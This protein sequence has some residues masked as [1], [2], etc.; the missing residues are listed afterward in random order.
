ME[1]VKDPRQP[2]PKGGFKTNEEDAR[3]LE[4]TIMFRMAQTL[5]NVGV[6]LRTPES[7]ALYELLLIALGDAARRGAAKSKAA[8]E[9]ARTMIA[10]RRA[11]D[12]ACYTV[13]GD[14][15]T[16]ETEEAVLIA[17]QD[18]VLAQIDSALA[19]LKTEGADG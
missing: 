6:N 5:K 9:A 10:G 18:S 7:P 19:G 16:M 4:Q 15:A 12:F 17:E 8:L 2:F 3:W 13:G 11:E 1:A 14:P